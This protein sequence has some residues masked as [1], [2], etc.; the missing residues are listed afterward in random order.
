MYYISGL[1]V[2]LVS[3]F[4]LDQLRGGSRRSKES[5]LLYT[6]SK[7]KSI[8]QLNGCSHYTYY[9]YE[10]EDVRCSSSP[11]DGHDLLDYKGRSPQV[12]VT[13]AFQSFM[14]RKHKMLPNFH[15]NLLPSQNIIPSQQTTKEKNIKF[16]FIDTTNDDQRRTKEG[17]RRSMKLS[18]SHIAWT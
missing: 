1:Y 18:R 8:L 17:A 11:P 5:G 9:Q 10:G 4:Y 15:A 6:N 2:R 3:R 16:F 12:K 14:Q 13:S 7:F